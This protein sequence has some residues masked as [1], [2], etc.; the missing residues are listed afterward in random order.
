MAK[1]VA[2][3]SRSVGAHSKI[4]MVDAVSDEKN[5]AM[6]TDT[7]LGH[8]MHVALT[9]RRPQRK[10]QVGETW[11]VDREFGQWG[12]VT[13]LPL[14]VPTVTGPVSD[15]VLASL[16]QSL[17]QMGYI[18]DGSVTGPGGGGGGGAGPT[19]PTGAAGSGA[20]GPTG[21]AGVGS[22]GPTGAAGAGGA[23]G[24]T[25]PGGGGGGTADQAQVS[26]SAT[27]SFPSA[28]YPG[29]PGGDWKYVNYDTL[30]AGSSSGMWSPGS[31]DRLTAIH[32]GWHLVSVSFALV[33]SVGEHDHI[34]GFRVYSSGGS[35]LS[36][37]GGTRT[38]R[39]SISE[40]TQTIPI[41][42]TAGQSV[43]AYVYQDTGSTRTIAS[44]AT[45]TLMT[46]GGSAG[47]S[48]I[49]DVRYKKIGAAHPQ[50]DEFDALSLDP[51]WVRVD[52]SGTAGRVT[53]TQAAGVLSVLNTGGD[54]SNRF[55]AL[56]KPYAL[57]VGEAIQ[58]SVTVTGK[59]DAGTF[60]WTGLVVSDGA[61]YGSGNQMLGS[62]FIDNTNRTVSQRRWQN[63][64]SG[65]AT[66]LNDFVS[67]RG[68]VHLRL[69]RDT[70]NVWR[71]SYSPDAVS[72]ITGSNLTFAMTPTHIGLVSSSFA[73]TGQTIA[74]YD[75][76]R[77]V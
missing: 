71:M 61:T 13:P 54:A 72:W 4:V 62:L 49:S 21:A 68:V 1:T 52:E 64:S 32:T 77:V 26:M 8:S 47:G 20:T 73:F 17:D 23:T 15:P 51:A 56:L 7:S 66:S 59:Q 55:H 70:G 18:E 76:F 19:G 48:Q 65:V 40:E 57:A 43:K 46:L 30:L 41:Y 22:A 35:P 44:G 69:L 3:G 16:L 50:D 63:W 5:L 38:R 10:P 33:E 36:Y 74:T 42:L 11:V 53:Y 34:V 25:G 39:A 58:C 9:P 45:M 6:C 37:A 27:Q 29:G 31:P 24:P 60:P 67:D 28:N 75:Y 2:P 12:F 14:R